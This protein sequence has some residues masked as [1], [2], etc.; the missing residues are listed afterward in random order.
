MQ[1]LSLDEWRRQ[2]LAVTVSA[3]TGAP[4]RVNS[5]QTDLIWFWPPLDSPVS[6]RIFIKT[7]FVGMAW[8]TK[9]WCP[10]TASR[11]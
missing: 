7:P 8:P 5:L 3:W 9:K 11:I 10:H 1:I 6:I 2:K 4:E